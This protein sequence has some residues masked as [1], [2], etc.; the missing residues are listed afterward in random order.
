MLIFLSFLFFEFHV[1]MNILGPMIY[2]L[3]NL[4]K[5]FTL[6]FHLPKRPRAIYLIRFYITFLNDINF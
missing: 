2:K 5:I 4:K 6:N 3:E 1:L